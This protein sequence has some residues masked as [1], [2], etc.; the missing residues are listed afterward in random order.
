MNPSPSLVEDTK[1]FKHWSLSMFFCH[2]TFVAL[3]KVFLKIDDLFSRGSTCYHYLGN[4]ISL[5][6]YLCCFQS[7]HFTADVC[8]CLLSN[9]AVCCGI[10]F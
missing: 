4:E 9:I 6:A 5:M 2:M 10:A 7:N 1:K 8:S 3:N